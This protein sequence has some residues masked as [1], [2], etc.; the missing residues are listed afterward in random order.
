MAVLSAVIGGEFVLE[1]LEHRAHDVL[2]ALQ[3]LVNIGV[4]LR[5]DVV[6]LP[7]MAIEWHLHTV[8]VSLEFVW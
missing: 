2:A 6:I 5:F 4:D 3:N 8:N 7:H 1:P